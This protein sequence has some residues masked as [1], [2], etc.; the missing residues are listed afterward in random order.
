MNKAAADVRSLM[1][2]RASLHAYSFPPRAPPVIVNS[3]GLDSPLAIFTDLSVVSPPAQ[4]AQYSYYDPTSTMSA[5]MSTIMPQSCAFMHSPTT[6]DQPPLFHNQMP[7]HSFLGPDYTGNQDMR[8]Q[9]NAYLN[10]IC[11]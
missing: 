7:Y 4:S 9:S 2:D 8:L 3:P 10:G 1:T 6:Q 5:P 11:M